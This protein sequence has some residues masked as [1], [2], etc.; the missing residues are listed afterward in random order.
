MLYNYNTASVTAEIWKSRLNVYTYG[1]W[2]QNNLIIIIYFNIN[3]L[4]EH[5]NLLIYIEKVNQIV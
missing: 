5:Y 4:N 3:S 2:K 1:K